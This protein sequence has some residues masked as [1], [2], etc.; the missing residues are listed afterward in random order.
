MIQ[1]WI[2]MFVIIIIISDYDGIAKENALYLISSLSPVEL[3]L[4]FQHS[5]SSSS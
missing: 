2:M 3:Y 4:Q 5:S 1:K